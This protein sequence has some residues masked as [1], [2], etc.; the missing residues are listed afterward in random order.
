LRWCTKDEQAAQQANEYRRAFLEK[1]GKP[2][3]ST[4]FKVRM[5]FSPKF[6]ASLCGFFCCLQFLQDDVSWAHSVID[7]LDVSEREKDVLRAEALVGV[8]VFFV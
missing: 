1:L 4:H 8:D 5:P 7:C 6:F 2:R 3:N